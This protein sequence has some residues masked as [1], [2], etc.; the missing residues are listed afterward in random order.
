M[1]LLRCGVRSVGWRH[2]GAAD[3]P[4]AVT[5]GSPDGL[6]VVSKWERFVI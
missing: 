1:E 3:A 4:P 2:T 6:G 5:A